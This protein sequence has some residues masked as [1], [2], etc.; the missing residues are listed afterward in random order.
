M[1]SYFYLSFIYYD[2]LSDPF[3]DLIFIFD[4]L[5]QFIWIIKSSYTNWSMPTLSRQAFNYF[6]IYINHISIWYIF[7]NNFGVFIYSFWYCVSNCNFSYS[8]SSLILAD[9]YG[10]KLIQL[11]LF[12]SLSFLLLSAI[13]SY[14]F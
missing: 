4:I 14:S 1:L 10:I 11:Y 6:F 8:F 3:R 13:Y 5:W 2:N 9:R 12:I 7:Q